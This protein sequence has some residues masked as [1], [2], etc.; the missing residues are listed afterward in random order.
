MRPRARKC[1][2][3][4]F[5]VFRAGTYLGRHHPPCAQLRTGAGDPVS[6]RRSAEPRGRGVLD[7]PPSRGMTVVNKAAPATRR[8]KDNG[9]V[10]QS[11]GKAWWD[12]RSADGPRFA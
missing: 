3:D 11:V 2:D 6:Q 7:T 8:T 4:R 9:I 5:G 1:L 12:T 10:R